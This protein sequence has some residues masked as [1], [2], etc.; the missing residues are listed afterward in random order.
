ML[1]I[2]N[3]RLNK[4]VV[5]DYI[6]PELETLKALLK[7]LNLSQSLAVLTVFECVLAHELDLKK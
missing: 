7:A 5:K 3:E 2:K 6:E 1:I 4:A